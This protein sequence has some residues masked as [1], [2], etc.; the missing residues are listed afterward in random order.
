MSGIEVWMTPLDLESNGRFCYVDPENPLGGAKD[1]WNTG[2]VQFP[3]TASHSF[4]HT[5]I[6]TWMKD[7]MH[8]EYVHLLL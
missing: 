7:L 5:H 4:Y 6:H 1:Q 2:P 8:A 3:V